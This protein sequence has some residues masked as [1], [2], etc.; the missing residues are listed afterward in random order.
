MLYIGSD[1]GGFKLKERIGQ[2]LREKEILISDMGPEK[3][4]QEDDYVDFAIRL[5]EKVTREA[6]SGILICRTGVGMAI[7]ANKVKGIRAGFCFCTKQARLAVE[8]NNINV[9]CLSADLV[10]EEENIEIVRTFVNTIFVAEER[11]V[12]RINKIKK[13]ESDR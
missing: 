4:E 2:F 8:D 9:L 13:Y 7:T 12:R 11:H 1:H 10:S 6:A 5:A 3:Y